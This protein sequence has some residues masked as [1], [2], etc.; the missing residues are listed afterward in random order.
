[1]NFFEGLRISGGLK[2]HQEYMKELSRYLGPFGKLFSMTCRYMNKHFKYLKG[3]SSD[4]KYVYYSHYE[5]TGNLDLVKWC[6]E[7]GTSDFKFWTVPPTL[8]ILQW[9]LSKGIQSTERIVAEAAARGNKAMIDFCIQKRFSTIDWEIC[10][11]VESLDYCYCVKGLQPGRNRWEDGFIYAPECVYEWAIQYQHDKHFTLA[12]LQ[13]RFHQVLQWWSQRRFKNVAM[14]RHYIQC[15]IDFP[16][17]P[18][19]ICETLSYEVAKA[20]SCN[21]CECGDPDN[22][23]DRRKSL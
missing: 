17:V 7:A 3:P 9:K 10:N 22:H 13:H 2:F 11:N 16:A 18:R 19:E 5:M 15:H 6:I 4:C 14:M 8:E 1:M 12:H 23:E 21:D 20:L